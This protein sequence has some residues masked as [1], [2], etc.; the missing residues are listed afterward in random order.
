MQV[1]TD[2]QMKVLLQESVTQHCLGSQWLPNIISDSP[3][4]LPGFRL[5]QYLVAVTLHCTHSSQIGVAIS[6]LVDYKKKQVRFAHIMSCRGVYGSNKAPRGL[7][8]GLVSQS[9][10]MGFGVI[11]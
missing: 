11:D 3:E 9:G 4:G 7:L 1:Y 5:Q 10:R 2:E 6:P 8:A